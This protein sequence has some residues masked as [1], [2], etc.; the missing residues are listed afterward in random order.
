VYQQRSAAGTEAQDRITAMKTSAAPAIGDDGLHRGNSASRG[1]WVDISK[2]PQ[3]EV[4]RGPTL[5]WLKSLSADQLARARRQE[6][7]ARHNMLVP[8]PARAGKRKWEWSEGGVGRGLVLQRLDQLKIQA[9]ARA[10]AM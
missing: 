3:K 2:L 10:R 4:T 1:S 6:L 9:E 7:A 5:V 8:D